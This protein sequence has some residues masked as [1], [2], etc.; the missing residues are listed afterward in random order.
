MKYLLK[1]LILLNKTVKI[2]FNQTFYIFF[3]PMIL[4]EYNKNNF[5][6]FNK[7]LL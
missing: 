2:L 6:D 5:N 7:Y 4:N 1:P 3:F